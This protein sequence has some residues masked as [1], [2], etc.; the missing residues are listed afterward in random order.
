MDTFWSDCDRLGLMQFAKVLDGVA[1]F[2]EYGKELTS[3]ERL[4][5][6]DILSVKKHEES[7]NKN[8]AHLRMIHGMWKNRW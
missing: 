7:D 4:M 3:E 5:V 8:Q 2:V 6:E 1:T